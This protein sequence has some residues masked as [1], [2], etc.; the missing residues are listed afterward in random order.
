MRTLDSDAEKLALEENDEPDRY[1]IQLYH[2]VASAVDLE[3]KE[4]LEVGSGRGGGSSYIKRYLKP[5]RMV[6]IDFS[7]NAVAFC[8]DAYSVDGLSYQT[9]DAEHLPFEDESFDAVV[10]VESSHC[11]GSMEAFLA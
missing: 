1:F 11:Y 3:D 8:N 4:V 9:G 6:G 5:R 10:N 7:A 2:H